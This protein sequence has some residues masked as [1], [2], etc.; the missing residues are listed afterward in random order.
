MLGAGEDEWEAG[1][2][3]WRYKKTVPGGCCG[4]HE[5]GLEGNLKAGRWGLDA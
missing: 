3:R 4:G 1:D 2:E 5:S